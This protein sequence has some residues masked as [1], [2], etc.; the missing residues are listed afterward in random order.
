MVPAPAKGLLKLS[1]LWVFWY[2]S[3]DKNVSTKVAA[4]QEVD[5]ALYWPCYRKTDVFD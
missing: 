1:S 5:I 4:V 2:V 3:T